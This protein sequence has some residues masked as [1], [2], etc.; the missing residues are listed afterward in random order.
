MPIDLEVKIGAL[1]FGGNGQG[2]DP[3]LGEQ[4]PEQIMTLLG[5]VGE[6]R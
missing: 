4:A 1:Y 3:T 6:D 2:C 5:D